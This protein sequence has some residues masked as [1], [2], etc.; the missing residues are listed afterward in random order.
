MEKIAYL[1]L[2]HEDPQNLSRLIN[3][4]DYQADFYIHVDLKADI[5]KFK[6]KVLNKNNIHFIQA[7]NHVFWAGFSQ[8]TAI[9]AL[10]YAVLSSNTQYKRFV[11]LSGS[12][13]P[14]KSNEEIHYFFDTNKEVEFIRGFNVTESGSETYDKHI[15]NYHFYEYFSKSVFLNKWVRR[16]LK[17]S[18]GLMPL[19]KRYIE[20]EDGRL[21]IYHGSSWW[22]LTPACASEM[23]DLMERY[24]SVL[25]TY[26][27]YSFAADE[28]YFHTLFFHSSFKNNTVDQG[29]GILEEISTAKWANVHHIHPSLAKW[30]TDSDVEEVFS[31]PKLFIRKVNTH[32]S[33]KL[34]DMIDERR[35]I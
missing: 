35:T 4:L 12:D 28:K 13:Y 34:L 7:R 18:V 32:D 10:L 16:L 23:V 19:K 11:Y 25:D 17:Y 14:L 5:N 21:D 8:V 30:Y 29:P 1:I 9:K 33:T 20:I 3:A 24:E 15:R 22:V 26:F 6:Q 2:V 27:N 31:S